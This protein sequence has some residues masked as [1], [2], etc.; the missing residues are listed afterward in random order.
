MTGGV[1]SL[2]KPTLDLGNAVY[3]LAL[4]SGQNDLAAELGRQA[5]L[6]KSPDLSV[7]VTGKAGTGKSSLLDC[8]L[9]EPVFADGGYTPTRTH[10]VVRFAE[11]R[12]MLLHR[13]DTDEPER[14][15]PVPGI[16][17]PEGHLASV[18][19][20]VPDPLLEAGVRLIDTPGIDA[21]EPARQQITR[22]AVA[23][24]DVLV[25]VTDASTP[26]SSPELEFLTTALR[27][28]SGIV[29]ALT[30]TDTARDW[31]GTLHADHVLV[32]DVIGE[33]GA[34]DIVPVSSRLHTR[35]RAIAAAGRAHVLAH[36]TA[37]AIARYVIETTLAGAGP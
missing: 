32:A 14:V 12:E 23:V 36:H 13:A 3:D 6:W 5:L 26:L 37:E 8:L 17:V 27:T 16:Q 4:R 29:V 21:Y 19:I 28:V 7:V 10:V 22:A 1:K 11:E 34:I 24:A 31:R 18:E 30:R 25:F 9:T 2:V 35:A 20:G 33:D 15:P